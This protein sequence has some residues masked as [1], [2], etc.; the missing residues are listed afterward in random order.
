M[1]KNLLQRPFCLVLTLLFI[2]PMGLFFTCSK[3]SKIIRPDI[4]G[5]KR[6]VHFTLAVILMTD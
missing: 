3:E 4:D 2:P 5:L 6:Q 1:L